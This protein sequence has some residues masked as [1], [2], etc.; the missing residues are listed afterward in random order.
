METS[1]RLKNSELSAVKRELIKRQK[2]LCPICNKSLLTC[3]INNVVVDHNHTT[4]AV[5]GALHRGCN[6]MEGK[7]KNFLMTWGKC[8]TLQDMVRTLE[9]LIVYWKLHKT[10]QTEWLHPTFKTDKEKEVLAKK[11]RMRAKE[12]RIIY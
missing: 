3:R 7:V 9:R 5:R 6:A 10:P 8:N 11:R 2:G 12:K 1:K 4:G